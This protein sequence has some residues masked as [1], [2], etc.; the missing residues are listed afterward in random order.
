[1]IELTAADWPR[2]RFA[3]SALWETI[4]AVRT[5]SRPHAQHL[6]QPWLTR[7]D[8]AAV[9]AQVPLLAAVNPP[10]GPAWVPD[11]LS[12]PPE[13]HGL[14][15]VE[16]ELARV[17]AY[18]P[19]FVRRDIERSLAS[20]PTP[21][22]A[23]ALQAVIDDPV[24]GRREFIRQLRLAWQLLAEPFWPA[25]SRVVGEDIAYRTRQ[26]SREGLGASLTGLH[27]HVSV[28]D[29]RI[30][31]S[32]AA[33]E[34]VA[35]AGRGL[36]LMPSVFMGSDVAVVHEPPWPPTLVYAARGIGN[37]WA[38]PDQPAAALAGLIG[39]S[40]ARL[41]LDLDADRT[42]STISL[43]HGLSPATTSAHLKRLAAAGLVTATRAGKEVRY[44]RTPL[45]DDLI[46]A[47]S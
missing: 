44:R 14:I 15:S 33:Q 22:R 8:Q 5:L 24:R 27:P 40:R 6:H 18:P 39:H 32:S 10:V 28:S 11:F 41:L 3:H 13:H 46:A 36:L 1:M 2:F 16:D 9:L 35:L 17:A 34:Q 7:V 43:R 31:V 20:Q 23:R 4:Q 30:V 26:A 19:R 21:S 25:I 42:T 12:P 45:A 29:S 37:L 47:S 38:A